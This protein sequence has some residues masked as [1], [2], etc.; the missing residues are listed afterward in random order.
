MGH[1]DIPIFEAR[2]QAQTTKQRKACGA[3]AATPLVD[4][5]DLFSW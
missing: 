1:R 2:P 4:S 5:G 3:N